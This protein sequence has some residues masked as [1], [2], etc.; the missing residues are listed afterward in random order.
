[1][2]LNNIKTPFHF[3]DGISPEDQFHM[4]LLYS[5]WAVLTYHDLHPDKIEK[6]DEFEFTVNTKPTTTITEMEIWSNSK[7]T[8]GYK[9]FSVPAKL[10]KDLGKM[11]EEVKKKLVK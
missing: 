10:G 7:R 2:A 3:G 1:M 4:I 6:I 5:K 8:E 11:V 9:N